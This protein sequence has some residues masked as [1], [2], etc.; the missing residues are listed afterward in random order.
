[1]ATT[2]ILAQTYDNNNNNYNNNI[3]KVLSALIIINVSH[4][5]NLCLQCK[6]QMSGTAEEEEA[7]GH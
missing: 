5:L 2:Y 1:M 3:W 6:R 7:A 4:L